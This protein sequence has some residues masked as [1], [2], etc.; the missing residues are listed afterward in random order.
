M[1]ISWDVNKCHNIISFEHTEHGLSSMSKRNDP[2]ESIKSN[3]LSLSMPPIAFTNRFFQLL[4][5]S[6]IKKWKIRNYWV[7]S[8][9]TWCDTNKLNSVSTKPNHHSNAILVESFK[10]KQL[11]K[12]RTN[13]CSWWCKSV[14]VTV[15]IEKCDAS[16]SKIE[17]GNDNLGHTPCKVAS[18]DDVVNL[19]LSCMALRTLESFIQTLTKKQ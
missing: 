4:F 2:I 16:S 8:F 3:G 12:Q 10:K 5:V 19:T 13:A 14:D 7:S 1:T 11:I 17:Q 15:K 6:V 9:V 18:I